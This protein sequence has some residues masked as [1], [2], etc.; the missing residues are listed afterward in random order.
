[1]RTT[2]ALAMSFS[3]FGSI[4]NAMHSKLEKNDNKEVPVVD[5]KTDLFLNTRRRKAI[6]KEQTQQRKK[7]RKNK[8]Q[9]YDK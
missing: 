9:Y 1:M 7:E 3:L 2:I 5:Q 6:I 8:F 4:A